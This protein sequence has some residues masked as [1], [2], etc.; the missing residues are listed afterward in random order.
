MEAESQQDLRFKG[1]CPRF[2]PYS[3]DVIRV[4]RNQFRIEYASLEL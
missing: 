2:P 1:R 3:L 4:V